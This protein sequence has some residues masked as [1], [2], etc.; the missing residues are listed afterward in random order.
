MRRLDH[1]ASSRYGEPM[2]KVFE[3]VEQI[4]RDKVYLVVDLSLTN[5]QAWQRR[6]IDEDPLDERLAL[7]VE[8]G[9]LR[10]TRALGSQQ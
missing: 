6:P 3:G 9:L 2:S 7:A 4:R 1:R 5:F 8:I 10:R